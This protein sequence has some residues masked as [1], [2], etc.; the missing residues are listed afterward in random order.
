MLEE[1]TLVRL[2]QQAQRGDEASR[3]I[4]IEHHEDFIARVAAAVC[5]KVIRKNDDEMSI[6]LIAFNEAIDRF[7]FSGRKSFYGY[8][9]LLIESRLI[10]YFRKERK[11]LGAISLDRPAVNDDSGRSMPSL[12]EVKQAMDH[13]HEEQLITERAEE[14]VQYSKLLKDYGIA[15]S[16]LET[17]AP[18]HSDTRATFLR[19]AHQFAQNQELVGYLQT[20][21]QLPLKQME[22]ISGVS[23]KTLERGRKY[24]IALIIIL[25]TGDLVHLKTT[26][27][28][29][30]LKGGDRS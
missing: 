29:P 14:I 17:S 21:K 7:Q 26:I 23:R 1:S 12:Y 9:R 10:D 27:R 25:I 16:E 22:Q 20:N 2:L 11:H 19:I 5:K 15:F 28:F 18:K 4:L 8:A 13:Y 6:G 30:D 24:L 3:K